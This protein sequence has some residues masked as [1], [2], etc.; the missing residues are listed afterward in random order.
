MTCSGYISPDKRRP[1]MSAMLPANRLA[2]AVPRTPGSRSP[3]SRYASPGIGPLTLTPVRR[4]SG[5][6]FNRGNM[7]VLRHASSWMRTRYFSTHRPDRS[8]G[9]R[10]VRACP[11]ECNGLFEPRQIAR[12][13]RFEGLLQQARAQQIGA[14]HRLERR[15]LRESGLSRHPRHC[16]SI[17]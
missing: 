7:E 8:R 3:L 16:R 6:G 14:R 1:G 13:A 5:M 11:A 10:L 12:R 4:R 9:W 2:D 17:D 15:R